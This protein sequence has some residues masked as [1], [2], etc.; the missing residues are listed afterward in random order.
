[1]NLKL[2]AR[3]PGSDYRYDTNRYKNYDMSIKSA[4]LDLEAAKHPD[5]STHKF[6]GSLSYEYKKLEYPVIVAAGG[7]YEFGY[8]NAS[9]DKWS[10]WVKV[11]SRF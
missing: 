11:G 4:D 10:A 8:S 2:H 1:V 6:Y 7:S 9:F 5:Y 3:K